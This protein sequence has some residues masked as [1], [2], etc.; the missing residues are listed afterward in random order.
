MF[1]PS[2]SSFSE[3]S[4]FRGVFL[5]KIETGRVALMMERREVGELKEEKSEVRLSFE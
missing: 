3:I 1:Y 5:M 4:R 2:T